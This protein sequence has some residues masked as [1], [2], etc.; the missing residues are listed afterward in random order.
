MYVGLW[1]RLEGFERPALTRAL[2]DRSVVV[3][4]LMR[5][6]IHLVSAADY[7]PHVMAIADARRDWWL[8]VQRHAIRAVEMEQAAERVRRRLRA[9]SPITRREL[10]AIAAPGGSVAV[11]L[12][13]DLV[14]VPPSSTWERRRADLF[15]LAEDWIGPPP[16]ELTTATAQAY[17]VRRYLEGFGPSSVAEIAGWA[18]LKTATIDAVLANLDLRR[19]RTDDG[20]ELV[21]LPRAPLP[22]PD[23][24]APVRFLPVWDAT[25]LAHARR[26]V[27]IEE[28]D[29]SRVFNTRTPHSLNTFTVDGCVAG[30]WV[31]K[32]GR[33]QVEPFRQL[34]PSVRRQVDDEAERVAAFHA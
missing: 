17:L 28:A 33:V 27:I 30:T 18:G 34:P 31:F 19:F 23:A 7:W 22:E 10:D 8:R 11:G 9:G 6:T 2:E 4:T 14:R 25:L 32:A 20:G 24:P 21:D 12:W 1:S 15:A 5:S 13:I 26:A 29:R 16:K 3:G